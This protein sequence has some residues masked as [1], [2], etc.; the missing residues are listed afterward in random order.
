M[1]D[2]SVVKLIPSSSSPSLPS[3]LPPSSSSSLPP[4]FHLPPSLHLPLPTLLLPLPPPTL[5]PLPLSPSHLPSLPPSSSPS[6]CVSWL[7]ATIPL[8]DIQMKRRRLR[9]R[10]WKWMQWFEVDKMNEMVKWMKLIK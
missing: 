4:S 10:R 5:L 7:T 1:Y 8:R 2:V 9:G 6:T 3:Y